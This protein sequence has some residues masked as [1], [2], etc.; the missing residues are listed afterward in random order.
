MDKKEFLE[1]F[2]AAKGF[3]DERAAHEANFLLTYASMAFEDFRV[4]GKLMALQNEIALTRDDILPVWQ[5][6]ELE[7]G[8]P[9][10]R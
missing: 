6:L 8:M 9:E 2:F 5:T 4:R 7:Y 3:S 10:K 1:S